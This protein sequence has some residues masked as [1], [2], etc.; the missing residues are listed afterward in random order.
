MFLFLFL[1]LFFVI[2][3]IVRFRYYVDLE[4][5]YNVCEKRSGM[6]SAGRAHYNLPTTE[7]QETFLS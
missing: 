1:L 5:F 3:K 4:I 6:S 7:M 2:G